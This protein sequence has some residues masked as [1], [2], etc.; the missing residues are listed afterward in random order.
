LIRAFIQSIRAYPSI[1]GKIKGTSKWDVR[2]SRERL[3][4]A[5]DAYS[6]ED[7]NKPNI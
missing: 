5:F 7:K 3:F 1:S 2:A 6:M 4:E